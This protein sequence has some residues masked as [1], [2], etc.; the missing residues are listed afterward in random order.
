MVI[1]L[2]NQE[3]KEGKVQLIQKTFWHCQKAE[4]Y[5]LLASVGK[6]SPL[7]S[8]TRMRKK[9]AYFAY[10]NSSKTFRFFF[11]VLSA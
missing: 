9:M 4:I 10:P 5:I 3:E 7:P 6:M 11:N 1:I 2:N 8:R